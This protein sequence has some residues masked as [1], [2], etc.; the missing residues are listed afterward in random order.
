MTQQPRLSSITAISENHV[1][2]RDNALIW[3]VPGD[4]KHFKDTTMGKP[5]IM[6][7]KSFEAL[8][9]RPLPGRDHII[10]SRNDP[11]ENSVQERV[12]WVKTIDEGIAK[13]RTLHDEEIFI[14]GG[15]EIYKQTIDLLDRLYLTI[16]H[17]TYEGD[18]FFPEITWDDWTITEETRYEGDPAYTIYILD[19]KV[20]R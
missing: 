20:Q 15:G 16:I 18:T 1:I 3:H 14:T 5:M 13:A 2:G 4:L 11:P 8:G 10:I 17:R 9:N 12:S 6:G 19:R 7:R